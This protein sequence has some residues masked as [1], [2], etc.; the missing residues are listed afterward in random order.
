[1]GFEFFKIR[2]SEIGEVLRVQERAHAEF[3]QEKA[4]SFIS[5][6]E[7]SPDTCFG[8]FLGDRLIGYGISFP[9]FKDKVVNLDC[10]LNSIG[11]KPEILYI[12]DIAVDP[13]FRGLGIAKDLLDLMC[14]EATLL[15]L[16]LLTL[17]AVAGSN[18]YWAR[19][20]FMRTECKVEGYGSG[21]MEMIL[22]LK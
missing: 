18:T 7:I 22:T 5:K 9:W 19:H 20:G 3:Y 1:M 6:I 10:S 8:A 13:D 2:A 4:E 12:H 15:E 14:H 21:A 17:V 16:S 11:E